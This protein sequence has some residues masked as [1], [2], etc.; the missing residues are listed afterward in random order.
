MLRMNY[1]TIE[2]VHYE[3][4]H[5][6]KD[7]GHTPIVSFD[8]FDIYTGIYNTLSLEKLEDPSLHPDFDIINEDIE[9]V[10]L[11]EMIEKHGADIVIKKCKELSKKIK[12]K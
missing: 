7:F 11:R 1:K 3:I 6:Q 2:L 4:P 10:E 9:F 5:R 12:T 8:T